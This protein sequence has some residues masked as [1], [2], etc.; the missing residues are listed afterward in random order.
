VQAIFYSRGKQN[1]NSKLISSYTKC[2][3]LLVSKCRILTS[4]DKINLTYL[5]TQ[6]VPRS[7]HSSSGL[8]KPIRWYCKE[9]SW[10]SIQK[11]KQNT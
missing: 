9:K 10:R 1:A 2:L 11:F 6:F 8:W 4:K 7:K 5:N 3:Y